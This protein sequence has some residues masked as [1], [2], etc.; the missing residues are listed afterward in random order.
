ME[1][2]LGRRLKTHEQ[3]HHRNMDKGD[4]RPSNLEV[5][6]DLDHMRKK[7]SFGGLSF[8]ETQRRERWNKRRRVRRR[9]RRRT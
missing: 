1:R 8:R 3:V 5:V 4:D 2:K 9:R 7:H 6:S